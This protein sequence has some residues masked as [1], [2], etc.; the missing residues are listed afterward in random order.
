VKADTPG[1]EVLAEQDFYELRRVAGQKRRGH[2]RV[3]AGRRRPR[4]QVGNA[5]RDRRPQAT[6]PG[7]LQ[8]QAADRDGR[9]QAVLSQ[10]VV[11]FSQAIAY[12]LFSHKSYIVVPKST[13]SDDMNK[14][15]SLCSLH[16]VGLV[17]FSRHRE[18]SDYSVV[19]LPVVASP[20]MFYVNNMLER[21]KSSV[22][23]LLNKLF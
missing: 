3:R 23:A 7:Y 14:L 10:P 18:Q 13:T 21:L 17:T 4:R 22:P 8:V 15:T 1:A 11:A 19:V 2:G 12:R 16:G 6:R 20:D 5:R 9:N